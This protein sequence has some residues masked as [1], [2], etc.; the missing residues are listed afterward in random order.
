VD[1]QGWYD[2]ITTT[3]T[4]EFGDHVADLFFPHRDDRQAYTTLFGGS[5]G[6]AAQI[7]GLATLVQSIAIT[8][9]AEPL[10]PETLR[11]LLVRT[12]TS[13]GGDGPEHIGPQPD[14]GRLLRVWFTP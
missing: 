6:A 2:A 8:R 11:N 10:S 13:Q 1:V 12:G 3:T 14:V 5:S 9:N 7:A 4:G